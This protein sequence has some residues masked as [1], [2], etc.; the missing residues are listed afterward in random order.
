MSKNELSVRLCERSVGSLFRS[1]GTMRFVYDESAKRALSLSMPLSEREYGNRYCEAFFGGLLPESS[2]AKTIIGRLFHINPNNSFNL[3]GAIGYDCA[4][5]VSIQDANDPIA[6]TDTRDIKGKPLN[7]E[8]LALHLRELPKRPLLAHLGEIRI[9]LAGVQDK[10]A[11]CLIEDRICLPENDSPSTHILKPP[12][13]HLEGSV[14]NEYF[15]L[16][17]AEAVGIPA[18]KV[19]IRKAK[20][21]VYLLVERYDRVFLD[22][23]HVKRVHQEDFC[24]ATA[25]M[26]TK[27]Y[28]SDGGPTLKKCFDLLDNT[29]SPALSRKQL[30]D[31][32]IFNCL[33][34]NADAHAKNFALLYSENGT[35]KLAPAYDIL[36][37]RIYKETTSKMAMAIGGEYEVE[38]IRK[39]NWQK[40]CHQN[41]LSFSGVKERFGEMIELITSAAIKEQRSLVESGFGS[42]TAMQI[43]DYTQTTGKALS[44]QLEL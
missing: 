36:C 29:T 17:L 28:Q 33:I 24:Q 13:S 5:A 15:C 35:V 19:Q 14:Q 23:Q 12:I 22:A 34:G 9:S 37:T 43:V 1:G 4:G 2:N 8:Q 21:I 44:N 40:F 41:G 18:A 32:V 11:L 3:L 42:A 31:M 27:K 10:A 6:L 20:D 39:G 30:L 25:T 26:S 16:K 7:A 38:N